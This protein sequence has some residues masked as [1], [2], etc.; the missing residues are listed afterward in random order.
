MFKHFEVWE[1][2]NLCC[3]MPSM[4]DVMNKLQVS[5]CG[6]RNNPTGSKLHREQFYI[7]PSPLSNFSSV[8]CWTDCV[9]KKNNQ[10]KT[11]RLVILLFL[12][13]VFARNYLQGS[14]LLLKI[15]LCN[16]AR[17][18][19][20]TIVLF[21]FVSFYNWKFWLKYLETSSEN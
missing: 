7:V 10:L 17:D 13:C 5:G 3:G 21:Y 11:R 1:R 2:R 18:L 20:V 6:I 19:I 9:K 16:K 4:A 12:K 15:I 14:R 8:R